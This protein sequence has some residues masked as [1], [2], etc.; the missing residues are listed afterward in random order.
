MLLVTA[1]ATIGQ[2]TGLGYRITAIAAAAV[3]V[4]GGV[5]FMMYNEKA[6]YERIMKK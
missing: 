3:C 1:F 6:V 2:E 4:L 5:I